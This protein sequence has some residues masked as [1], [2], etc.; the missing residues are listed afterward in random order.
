MVSDSQKNISK[1]LKKV[2]KFQN[3]LLYLYCSSLKEWKYNK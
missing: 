1:K 3:F 2:W